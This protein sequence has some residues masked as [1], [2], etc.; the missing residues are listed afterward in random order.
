V[1]SGAPVTITRVVGS[2]FYVTPT[3]LHAPQKTQ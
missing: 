3:P 1:P 2:Q